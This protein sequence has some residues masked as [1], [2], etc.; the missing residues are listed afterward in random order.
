M[1][2]NSR[3]IGLVAAL[4]ALGMLT[5]C[6]DDD[7]GKGASGATANVK[8]SSDIQLGVNESKSS[9]SKTEVTGKPGTVKITVSVPDDAKGQHG[10]GID[11]GV[12]K[13]VDGAPVKAGRSTSLTVDLK[14][15]KY[16]IY[17]SY[18]KNRADGY[19]TTLT[20]SK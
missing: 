8:I 10:V 3:L 19:E 4:M 15:G 18:K 20:V 17:D 2:I 6:G 12:Y 11:G 5:G 16:T 1:V 14:P 7:D 9:F 13:N